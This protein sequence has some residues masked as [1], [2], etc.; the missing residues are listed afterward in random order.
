[1][2]VT[3]VARAK[4]RPKAQLT[5]PDEIRRALHIGEGDEVEFSVHDDGTVTIRGFVSIPADQAWFWTPEWQ[6]GEGQATADIIAGRT[7][8][9]RSAEDMFAY[10]DSGDDES[11]DDA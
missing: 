3:S 9:H 4:V 5:L 7:T 1:M 6:A 8:F 10:L 11:G 2:S